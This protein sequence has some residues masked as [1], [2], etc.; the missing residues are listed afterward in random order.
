[1][2]ILP[3]LLFIVGCTS[4]GLNKPETSLEWKQECFKGIHKNQE[5]CVSRTG[6]GN[7]ITVLDFHGLGDGVKSPKV[8]TYDT[9]QRVKL[10]KDIGAS[11][12]VSISY[13]LAWML[14]PGNGPESVGEVESMLKSL[15]EEYQ[16]PPGIVGM[17]MSMGGHNLAT[18]CMNTGLLSKCILLN[19]ML[20]HSGQYS[21]SF[22][23]ASVKDASIMPGKHFTKAEWER[24]NPFT[25]A[26]GKDGSKFM[27]SACKQDDFNLHPSTKAWSTLINAK[28]MEHDCDH[29]HP[30]TDGVAEFIGK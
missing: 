30:N 18:F 2:K 27:V 11:H 10:I 13:G 28:F 20:L 17:G 23:S 25:Q 12:V 15:V 5:Y 26:L 4:K 24:F 29:F 1:M 3:L 22:S 21:E 7:P 9:S 19:P 16:L 6:Y 14:R 8:S